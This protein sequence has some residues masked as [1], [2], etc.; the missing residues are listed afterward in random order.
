MTRCLRRILLQLP[1]KTTNTSGRGENRSV[2]LAAGSTV[3]LGGDSRIDV[4][5]SEHERHIE[6]VRGE[7]FFKVAHD[8]E[9]PPTVSA[10][11]AIVTAVGTAFDARCGVDKVLVSVVEGRVRVEP[12]APFV[13]L[14][15]L[16]SIQPKLAPLAVSAGQETTV[17]FSSLGRVAN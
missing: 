13:P 9:R 16:T 11:H 2:S 6:L 10:G 3:I 17:E 8:S 5:Y 7:A 1:R 15:L 12:W 4:R 14:A